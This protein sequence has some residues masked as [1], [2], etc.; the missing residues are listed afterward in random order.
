MHCIAKMSLLGKL[1]KHE[2]AIKYFD[3]AIEIDPEI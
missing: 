2:D 1:G 3:K